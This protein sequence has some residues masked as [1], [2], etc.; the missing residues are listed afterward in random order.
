MDW[1]SFGATGAT[2]T[3][4]ETNGVGL[5]LCAYCSFLNE[6][7][8]SGTTTDATTT[9]TSNRGPSNG[10]IID[11]LNLFDEPGTD[12]NSFA[13]GSFGQVFEAP[14]TGTLSSFS[15]NL[16]CK[17]PLNGTAPSI[18]AA[19]YQMT[20][21]STYQGMITT[22]IASVNFDFSACP[23]V[24]TFNPSPT[25][26]SWVPFAF[27]APVTAGTFYAVLMTG[28]AIGGAQPA[29][30]PTS[31]TGMASTATVGTAYSDSVVANGSPAP[32]YSVTAGALPD[33]LS[34]NPTTG[35]VTGTPTT[36]GPYSFEVT[37]TNGGGAFP[38]TFTGTVAAAVIVTPAPVPT[39][40]T[41]PPVTTTPPVPT[42]SPAPTPSPA[43]PSD[44][45]LLVPTG[46]GAAAT[47]TGAGYWALTPG[48]ALSNHGNAGNLGSTN[49]A[50]LNAPIVAV[51]STTNGKGYWLAGADGGVFNYGD[52]KFFGS[53]GTKHITSP[54]VA[55]S[56][57]PDNGGYL[58]A[59]ANGAVYAFGDA[60]LEG[61][62][63]TK[64]LNQAITS[65]VSSPDGKG[66][67]LV[68]TDGG[69]FNYGDAHF[70]GSLGATDVNKHIVGIAATPDGKGYWLVAANGAV[71][72]FGDARFFGS[73]G[74]TGKAHVVGIVADANVGYRLITAQ[75]N[76]IAFG[77]TPS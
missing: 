10:T 8:I 65:M 33:G 63:A 34:L 29:V 57:T 62:R 13:Q 67:L 7:T 64:H 71:F 4:L 60:T 19:L 18:Y 58:L 56:R 36:A 40:T 48:G 16:A 20:P 1:T 51:G 59:S 76:A 53:L 26:F 23:T 38:Q 22:K 14:S 68:G 41:L 54:V 15:L 9:A 12:G 28:T 17:I 21:Q 47:P 42:T 46:G 32:T 72:S 43:L 75:G 69:V 39:T 49:T 2:A 6:Y 27:N 25:T 31:I 44:S 77:T 73:L 37:A 55:M 61:S 24:T 11:H 70:E 5:D 74:A 50:K 52:A 35:A 3:F 66:Y 30:A 45:P